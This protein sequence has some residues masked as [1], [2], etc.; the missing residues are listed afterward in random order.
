MMQAQLQLL[1][2]QSQ[3]KIMPTR[4]ERLNAVALPLV[5]VVVDGRRGRPT[6]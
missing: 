5:S 1:F 6:R 3:A 4:R 2:Q